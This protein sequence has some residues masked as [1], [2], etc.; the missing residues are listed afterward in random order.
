MSITDL[1]PW[2]RKERSVPS[3]QAEEESIFALQ[4]DMNRLFDDFF[5][6]FSMMPW[7]GFEEPALAFSPQ[8]DLVEDEDNIQVSTELPGMDEND[9]DVS[10]SNGTLTIRGEKQ[11]EWEDR[12]ANYFRRERTFGS[13][14][15]SVPLPTEVD[16]DQAEA[17]CKRG[18]LTVTLPKTAEAKKKRITIKAG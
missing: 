12:G 6:S 7:R 10:I 3:R 13:F 11:Q 5:R 15:R 8:L 18:V 1:I 2:R 14:R 4:Q 16:Q 9:I 17:T